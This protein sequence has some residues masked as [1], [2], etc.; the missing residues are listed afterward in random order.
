MPWEGASPPTQQS[1][2]PE[3]DRIS[4]P[5]LERKEGLRRGMNLTRGLQKAS[6]GAGS[7]MGLGASYKDMAFLEHLLHA[8]YLTPFKSP[9]NPGRWV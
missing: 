4:D 2:D 8:T 3:M 9:S 1:L 7:K 6:S 5:T